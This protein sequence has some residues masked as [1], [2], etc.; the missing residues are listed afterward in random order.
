MNK[1]K[2]NFF[3]AAAVLTAVLFA[4][5]LILASGAKGSASV[6][7]EMKAAIGFAVTLEGTVG[8]TVFALWFVL[9]FKR[10]KDAINPG[11]EPS[12]KLVCMAASAVLAFASAAAVII[13]S[14][15]SMEVMPNIAIYAAV[16]GASAFAG[17]AYTEM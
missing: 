15:V 8:A 7:E 5:G 9:Y 16:I 14:G 11:T 3:T 12:Q 10:L 1:V 6:D 17:A 13:T 2:R 4:A